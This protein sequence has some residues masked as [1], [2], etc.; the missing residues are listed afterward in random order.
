M[1]MALGENHPQFSVVIPT[2][3]RPQSL[4]ACLEALAHQDFPHDNFEVIVVTDGGRSSPE[5]LLA[6]YESRISTVLLYQ[7]HA[8]PARARNL[9]SSHARG[10]FLAFTDD[11]CR[12]HPQWLIKLAERL[13][14]HPEAAIGGRIVN[15]LTS[16]LFST[17]SQMLIDYLYLYYQARGLPTRFF[18]TANLALAKDRFQKVGGFDPKFGL[19]GGE[20]REFCIRWLSRGYSLIYAPEVLV[21]HAHPLNL[22]TFWGQHFNYGR[23][24]FQFH[25]ARRNYSA[26]GFW[27]EPFHFYWNLLRHPFA[28]KPTREAILLTSLLFLSQLANALGFFQELALSRL[29]HQGA[30]RKA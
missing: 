4:A 23:G 24:A 29:R 8:G 21:H 15:A 6:S 22:L 2:Y 20:D 25:R 19:A 26:G 16:N 9:G 12:P 10:D 7:E 5:K 3:N 14:L 13:T 1:S 28:E 11:D 30:Y 17:A 27:L 18:G